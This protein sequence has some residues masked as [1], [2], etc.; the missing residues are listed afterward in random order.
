VRGLLA[1]AAALAA[2]VL[3]PASACAATICVGTEAPGCE[4]S[5]PNIQAALEKAHE[6]PVAD[7]VVV[8]AGTFEGPFAYAG[9]GTGGRIEVVG[10][11]PPTV[12]TAPPGSNPETVL[13][14]A[15]DTQGDGAVVSN[16][17]VR[18]PA[19]TNSSA[20]TGIYA[21]MVS[22][23]RV[24][25]DAHEAQPAEPHGVVLGTPGGSLRKSVVELVGGGA[26][27][28]GVETAGAQP[29]PT[30]VA[31]SRI[32]APIAVKAAQATDVVRSRILTVD[33]GVGV[34][35]CNS[36]VTV[37]DSLIRIS[38][39]GAGLLAFGANLCG[40]AQ[41][42]LAVREATIVGSG[43]GGAQ[44]GA[45]AKAGVAGQSP[46]VDVSLSVLR[47]LHVAFEALGTASATATV[48]V[49]ASDFEASRHLEMLGGGAAAFHVT[50]PNI[51]A[52]PLFASELLS[53]FTLSPGSPAIDS[54]FSPP[55]S[56]GES[57]TDL[58]GDPRVLDGNGDGVAT[59]DM[60]AFEAPVP[61]DTTPPDTRILHAKKKKKLKLKAGPHGLLLRIGFVSTEPS[62]TFQC[63][64]DAGKF[65]ACSSPFQKRLAA[66]L[67]RFEV[68]AV[69]AAGNVDP[70]PARETV[71]IAQARHGPRAHRR[72]G[73]I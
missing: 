9:G 10:Q 5:A 72:H 40:V 44:V 12:L 24:S 36:A 41:S 63:R 38:G 60:G 23:V 53:E 67:H 22:E 29:T 1:I 18:L 20:D 37:E 48:S 43:T 39:S 2:A 6:S 13:R 27:G 57:T 19:S 33:G 3:L 16:L 42:S 68:R 69:D 54:A 47:G 35:A 73:T 28:I 52:D 4:A 51:D 8:G 59:R 30:T 70:T 17:T 14:L 49:G 25:S 55:L 61:P 50:Q 45:E 58:A 32:T 66:G 7:R 62:S 31:D 34:L 65:A 56:A 64:I 11:G 71:R 15:G 26:N 46:S 21:E